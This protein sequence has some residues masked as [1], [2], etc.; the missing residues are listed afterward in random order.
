MTGGADIEDE[1]VFR[2]RMLRPIRSR[3]RAAVMPTTR[4][5]AGGSRRYMSL[6]YTLACW[7][8]ERS[9]CIS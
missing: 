6:G 7:A 4:V 8:R 5:G 3:R 9:A 2:S 1:E